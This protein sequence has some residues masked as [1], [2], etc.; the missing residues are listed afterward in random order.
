M[1]VLLTQRGRLFSLSPWRA[2]ALASVVRLEARCVFMTWIYLHSYVY[3]LYECLLFGRLC[4]LQ[5]P[6]MAADSRMVKS[7]QPVMS[8]RGAS[9]DLDGRS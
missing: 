9:G 3:V 4:L 2:S 7:C 1:S 5:L 8:H 6:N